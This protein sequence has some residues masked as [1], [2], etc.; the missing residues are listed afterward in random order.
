MSV[1]RYCCDGLCGP[2]QA[3]CPRT[4]K[5]YRSTE[6]AFPED[7]ADPF[8]IPQRSLLSLADKALRIAAV[9]LGVAAVAMFF[10]K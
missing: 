4:L 7:R 10:V 8:D 1:S 6:E 2:D 3:K 9:L 5:I